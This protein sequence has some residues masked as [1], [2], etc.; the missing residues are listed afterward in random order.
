MFVWSFYR[1][2]VLNRTWKRD[3]LQMRIF[4]IVYSTWSM[5][6]LKTRFEASITRN[7]LNGV[8]FFHLSYLITLMANCAHN[9]HQ[10]SKSSILCLNGRST[11][12]LWHIG[13]GK[14]DSLQIMKFVNVSSTW[15]IIEPNTCFMTWITRNDVDGVI[16]FHLSYM[17]TLMAYLCSQWAPTVQIKEFMFFRS[18]VYFC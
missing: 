18:T 5:V 11:V 12:Y 10:L 6:Q 2:F 16:L 7:D 15:R 8:S 4:L 9:G 17:I 3:S 13:P 1:P 14:H